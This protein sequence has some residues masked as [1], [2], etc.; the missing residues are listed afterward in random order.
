MLD[1]IRSWDSG[2]RKKWRVRWKDDISCLLLLTL[3]FSWS[4][5]SPWNSCTLHYGSFAIV[6]Y[7]EELTTKTLTLTLIS[8]LREDSTFWGKSLLFGG[9]SHSP[10]S[11]KLSLTWRVYLKNLSKSLHRLEQCAFPIKLEDSSQVR[12]PIQQIQQEQRQQWVRRQE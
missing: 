12:V 1:M 10:I 11:R 7:S 9:N 6:Q 8:L 4:R 3:C 2:K 5:P